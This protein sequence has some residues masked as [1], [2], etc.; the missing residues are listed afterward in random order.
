MET[1]ELIELV[2]ETMLGIG[3]DTAAALSAFGVARVTGESEQ[4]VA[5]RPA[6]SS[7]RLASRDMELLCPAGLFFREPASLPR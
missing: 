4:G 3:F 6:V 2:C 7:L 5:F 1:G